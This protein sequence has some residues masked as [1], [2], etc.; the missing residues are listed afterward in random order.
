[1]FVKESDQNVKIN[2]FGWPILN[3]ENVSNKS[4]LFIPNMLL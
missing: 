2:K 1:M 3:S 4:V